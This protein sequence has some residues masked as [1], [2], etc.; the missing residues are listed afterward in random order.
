MAGSYR[1][2]VAATSF[3]PV[4]VHPLH[5]SLPRFDI[6]GGNYDVAAELTAVPDGDLDGAAGIARVADGNIDLASEFP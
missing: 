1:K 6:P 4:H 2:S 3:S 5:R